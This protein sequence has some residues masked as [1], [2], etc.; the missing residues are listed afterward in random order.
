MRVGALRLVL[1]IPGNG[2]LKGKRQVLHKVRDRV[3]ARFKVA[4]SEVEDHD[5]HDRIVLGVVAVGND[6]REL[7]SLLDRVVA[8][9]ESLAVARLEDDWIEVRVFP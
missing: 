3:R 1:G 4:V 8:F 2:S 9:V 6:S 7:Q 5:Q